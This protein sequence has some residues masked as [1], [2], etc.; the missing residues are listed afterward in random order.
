MLNKKEMKE[1]I[2]LALRVSSAEQTEIVIHEFDSALT[3]FANNY[4]HQNVYEGNTV[5]SVRAI[6]GK[7]IGA[8]STN[9]LLPQKIKETVKWAERIARYQ[10]ENTK[11]V[12]LIKTLPKQYHPVSPRVRYYASITPQKRAEAVRDIIEVAK[13]HGLT[14][15]GSVSNGWS[16]IT[17]GNSLGTFAYYKSGDVFC[18]IVMSG[19]DSTGYV[20]AGAKSL[21]ELNFVKLA[22]VAAKKAIKSA[23]PIEIEPKSYTTIFEPLAVADFMDYLAVY[24]F[25]GKAFEEGRSYLAGRLGTKIVDERITIVDDPFN[26]KGFPFPF[27]FEGIPKNKLVLIEK[28]VAQNVVYDSLTAASV[29]KKTT[30]HALTYPNPFGPIPLHLVMNRG[31]TEIDDIISNTK[32]GILV[33]RLH[34]TNV[35]DPYR[36]VFTGMT[37]DG[38]F[39]IEDGTI[40]KGIKNLRFTENLFEVLNRVESISK[41][42]ELVAREPGY[43]SRF[44]QGTIVPTIKIRDFTFTSKTQY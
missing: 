18:N 9:S 16:T 1:L 31:D 14:A 10:V 33:T 22:E 11:F 13:K 34:Y 32:K 12:S 23:D 27:D 30:G 15:F 2:E 5:V 29:G 44:S 39:L 7:K 21:N 6:F 35:I 42:L 38:T 36:I 43:G 3:R 40:T 4:I 8:A 26:I 25:N 37:R 28:G 19:K 20:Q 24:A 41:N 17:I